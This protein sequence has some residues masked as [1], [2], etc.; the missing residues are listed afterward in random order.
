MILSGQVVAQCCLAHEADIPQGGVDMVLIWIALHDMYNPTTVLEAAKSI[1]APDGCVL[2]LE[3][4]NPDNFSEVA[5][6]A[7]EDGEKLRPVTKFCLSVS[8][9]HCLPVSKAIDPSQAI[10][11][12]ISLATIQKI[13]A[14]A[15]F[16]NVSVFPAN[17]TMRMY[18]F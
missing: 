15:G 2:V 4:T 7:T 17:E 18:M 16:N 13:A 10:G 3:F 11:T 12:S 8:V 6:G 9:L 1:L 5:T 14:R